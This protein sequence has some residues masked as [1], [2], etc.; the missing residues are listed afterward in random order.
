[1]A[2]IK[3]YSTKGCPICHQLKEFLKS[4]NLEFQD[5]D[6]QA[7]H[8]KAHEMVEKSGQMG[9]PVT[10]VDGQVIVGFDKEKFKEI[11]GI[12]DV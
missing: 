6:V 5:I 7:D 9:V 12:Q 3:V 10:E 2:E 1:M 11:L 4:N 8:A